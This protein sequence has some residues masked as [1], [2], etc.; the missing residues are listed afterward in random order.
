MYN[1]ASC[2]GG[3]V[4]LYWPPFLNQ[5]S[6]VPR[7]NRRN[8]ALAAGAAAA[9][10]LLYGLANEASRQARQGLEYLG[11]AAFN[12]TRDSMKRRWSGS[13]STRP[14]KRRVMN[15]NRRIAGLIGLEVKYS[16]VYHNPTVIPRTDLPSLISMSQNASTV[17]HITAVPQ[18]S[19][20]TERIGRNIFVRS[21]T[22]KVCIFHRADTLLADQQCNNFEVGLYLILDKQAN[23]STPTANQIFDSGNA[24]PHIATLPFINLEYKER[25]RILKV[26]KIKVR[27]DDDAS[28]QA[29]YAYTKN[30]YV[31]FKKPWKQQ[32]DGTGASNANV[33]NEAMYLFAGVSAPDT[34][35]T[36]QFP[37][38][39]VQARTRYTS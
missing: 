10:P 37:D 4:I 7:N 25:F 29:G 6:L 22:V 27:L 35:G 19:G 17:T 23:S 24:P 12:Y 28:R 34:A 30:M 11:S 16:D 9:G 18:G 31:S 15:Q 36:A 26:K 8:V 13:N 3:Q 32:Y 33:T 39:Y 21:V 2:L 20:E 5:M 1:C 38:I 14:S